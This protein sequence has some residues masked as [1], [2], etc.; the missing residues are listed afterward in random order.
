MNTKDYRPGNWIQ[1]RSG[2]YQQIK[3]VLTTMFLLPN[4]PPLTEWK[5][6]TIPANTV[7][8][9]P[10]TPEIVESLNFERTGNL[11]NSA[12]RKFYKLGKII[13]EPIANNRVAV[14]IDTPMEYVLIC[15]LDYVHELQNF[16]HALLK[17]ELPI[18]L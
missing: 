7:K 13:L 11:A 12:I 5:S 6:M 4:E 17:E 15:F 9:V 14:Y 3:E 1:R 10:I 18:T 2:R 8:P 16:Y